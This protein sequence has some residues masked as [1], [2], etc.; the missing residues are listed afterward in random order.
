MLETD[1]VGKED[2]WWNRLWSIRHLHL[3]KNVLRPLKHN[4]V[5]L[6]ILPNLFFRKLVLNASWLLSSL[7]IFFTYWIFG[8]GCKKKGKKP[9]DLQPWKWNLCWASTVL[10]D[11]T[12]N[13]F[14][15]LCRK[16]HYQSAWYWSNLVLFYMIKALIIDRGLLFHFKSQNHCSSNCIHL[17]LVSHSKCQLQSIQA[18]DDSCGN[19]CLPL[20]WTVA[21]LS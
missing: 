17:W 12:A 20:T 11:C 8:R 4:T 10:E 16:V 6:C 21:D 7:L 15:W 14:C 18:I 9:L 1:K 13:K 5:V 2:Y 19:R 3:Q